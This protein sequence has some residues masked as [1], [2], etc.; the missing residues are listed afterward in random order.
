MSTAAILWEFPFTLPKGL[1]DQTGTLHRQGI[2][3]LATARDELRVSRDRRV[4]ADP[5][6]DVFVRLSQV[7]TQLGNLAEPTAEQ[8]EGLFLVDLAF[9][10]EFYNR[11]NQQ[12]NAYLPVECPQC[13]RQFRVELALSGE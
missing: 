11:I 12:G 3:R 9:L 8:L 4:Q 13:Q 6:Y 7:I 1:L 5:G 10:R 2:M